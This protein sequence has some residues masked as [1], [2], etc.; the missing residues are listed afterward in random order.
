MTYKPPGFGG[1]WGLPGFCGEGSA[2]LLLVWTCRVLLSWPPFLG[3]V[4]ILS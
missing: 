1:W 4:L 3:P 2:A